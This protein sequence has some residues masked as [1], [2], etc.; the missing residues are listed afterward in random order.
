MT[1]KLG[2]RY[3]A[4]GDRMEHH[5]TELLKWTKERNVRAM[6]IVAVTDDD[7]LHMRTTWL[8]DG[9]TLADVDRVISGLDQVH[10]G[11]VM[12]QINEGGD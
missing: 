9:A 1:R 6:V 2:T 7:C 10:H 5:A 8:V 4:S 3:Q 11:L 12:S